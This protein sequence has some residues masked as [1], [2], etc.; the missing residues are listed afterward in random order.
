MLYRYLAGIDEVGKGSIAG[1]VLVGIVIFDMEKINLKL[2]EGVTDSKKLSS[3]RREEFYNIIEKLSNE[4]NLVFDTKSMSAK[5]IDNLGILKCVNKCATDLCDKYVNKSN[6]SILVDYGIK[7]EN[8]EYKSII[9]GDEK[10]LV[11]SS[12][13]IIA[14]VIRDRKM[15]V[16]SKKYTGYNLDENKGYGTKKHIDSINRIGISPIHRKTF[17]KKYIKT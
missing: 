16:N 3:K 1:E 2:L 12:A 4:D 7:L 14:K 10:E 11:I 9:K 15:V 5:D 6:T 13:S 17:L 8:F